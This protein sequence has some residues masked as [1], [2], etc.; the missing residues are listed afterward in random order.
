MKA[1]KRYAFSSM[2]AQR[3]RKLATSSSVRERFKSYR[4]IVAGKRSGKTFATT[5]SGLATVT[6][7]GR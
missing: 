2:N 6:R 4:S 7:V 5:G 1:T 3:L